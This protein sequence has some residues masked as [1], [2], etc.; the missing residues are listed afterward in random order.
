MFARGE[1]RMPLLQGL[2]CQACDG[3]PGLHCRLSLCWEAGEE[4]GG[5]HVSQSSGCQERSVPTEIK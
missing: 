4:E 3:S 2:R 5:F 1:D